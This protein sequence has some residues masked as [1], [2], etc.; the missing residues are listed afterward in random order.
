[1]FISMA[2]IKNNKSNGLKKRGMYF[3]I[4]LQDQSL[5]SGVSK[6]FSLDAAR[7]IHVFGIQH[8]VWIPSLITHISHTL[9]SA[10]FSG[11]A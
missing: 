11:S 9:P 4:A 8:S 2:V 10:S 3:L 6:F 5:P 1:M 7:E